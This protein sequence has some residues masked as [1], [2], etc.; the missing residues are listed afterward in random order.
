MYF[1]HV[2]GAVRFTSVPAFCFKTNETVHIPTYG[3]ITLDIGYGGAFYA[4]VDINQTKLDICETPIEELIKFAAEVTKTVKHAIP[5][6]H[7]DE[8]DL[9]FLYGT[10]LTDGKDL[11][12]EE[13]TNNLCVFADRQVRI[14]LARLETMGGHHCGE[15][16]FQSVL[17]SLSFTVMTAIYF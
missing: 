17:K 12:S 5:C 10:I 15:K 11:Y 7:P 16:T 1:I 2:L 13:P 3:N 8:G 4:L 6:R 9:S 14:E